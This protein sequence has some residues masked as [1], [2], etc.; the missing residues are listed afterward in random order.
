MGQPAEPV[1]LSPQERLGGKSED[2]RRVGSAERFDGPGK[3]HQALSGARRRRQD[4]I[5]Q[6]RAIEGL[7]NAR[8]VRVESALDYTGLIGLGELAHAGRALDVG[9]RDRCRHRGGQVRSHRYDLIAEA[10]EEGAR[11]IGSG[12]RPLFLIDLT[13]R[14]SLGLPCFST[15]VLRHCHP[16]TWHRLT[17]PRLAAGLLVTL[18]SRR[19]ARP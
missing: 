6:F 4:N 8:L 13:A 2:R 14:R 15:R 12:G 11:D 19:R 16:L 7:Q 10:I 17:P 9:H 5:R 3:K 1:S 18:F